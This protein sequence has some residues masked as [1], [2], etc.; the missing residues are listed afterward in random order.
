MEI[1][2]GVPEKQLSSITV[3]PSITTIY[4]VTLTS[5]Q[6]CSETDNVEV[7]VKIHQ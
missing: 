6:G 2:Y 7:I 5:P 4:Y 1:F 3:S